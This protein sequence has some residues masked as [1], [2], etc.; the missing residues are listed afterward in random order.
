[1]DVFKCPRINSLYSLNLDPAKYYIFQRIN[2]EIKIYFYHL[3]WIEEVSGSFFKQGITFH[4]F[5]VKTIE[6]KK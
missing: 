5:W 3:H 2:S 1:M 4:T 6:I